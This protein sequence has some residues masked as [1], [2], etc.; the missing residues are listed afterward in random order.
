MFKEAKGLEYIIE[1]LRAFYK[2]PGE[3]DSKYISE[4]VARGQIQDV[5]PSYIAKILP[6]MKKAGMI[7]SSDVG[8]KLNKNICEITLKDVLNTCV[9][10]DVDSY[11]FNLCDEILSVAETKLLID[12][13][14]FD[15]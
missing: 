4:L 7:E 9:L 13:Y 2:Y 15:Q 6:K 14:E 10:P 8:Y 11:L 1:I 3:H 12:V 5:S